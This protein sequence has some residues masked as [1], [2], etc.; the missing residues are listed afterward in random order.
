[1]GHQATPLKMRRASGKSQKPSADRKFPVR[2]AAN[3]LPAQ[4]RVNPNFS[5][6]PIS[7]HAQGAPP[8]HLSQEFFR[9]WIEAH[10]V[11]MAVSIDSNGNKR[12]SKKSPSADIARAT[13]AS[14]QFRQHL[15]QIRSYAPVRM[16]VIRSNGEMETLPGG[17]DAA[18]GIYTDPDG[19]DWKSD[20]NP[21]QAKNI[22]ERIIIDFPFVDARSKSVA[23]AAMLTVFGR[24][25][26]TF[27][28]DLRRRSLTCNLFVHE[29]R[30][31]DR[32]FSQP[33]DTPAMLTIQDQI[34]SCLWAL[35]QD[36]NHAGRPAGTGRNASFQ[37]WSDIF[38]A[39]L[40]HAGYPSPA[41]AFDAGVGGDT[42]MRD[43]QR[44][45][46]ELQPPV[47]YQF[48]NLVE[49]CREIGAFER[50]LGLCDDEM[51][52]KKKC[53]FATILKR[54]EGKMILPNRHWRIIGSG[55]R[56]RYALPEDL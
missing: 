24:N 27:T 3:S 20:L 15:R 40:E 22:L 5:P 16:P 46:K 11:P 4:T 49:I 18:S 17:F 26:C 32:F 47:N 48:S 30:A 21:C 54:Y 19:P 13:L 35:I 50:L 29:L 38:G 45:A 44:L 37:R 56:R 6:P 43:M 23:L 25:G 10:V 51:E 1:M 2:L 12:F 41:G 28:P 8:I 31:E 39:I 55:H 53:V 42:D 36:W 33:L 34:M 14:P 52:R 7:P 9:S